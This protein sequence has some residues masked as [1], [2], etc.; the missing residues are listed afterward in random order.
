MTNKNVAAR[1]GIEAHTVS[2][3]RARFV[4]DRLEGLTDEPC[5]GEPRKITDDQVE[6]AIVRTLESTPRDATHWS[7][8]AMATGLGLSQ[9]AISPIWR[10]F[11]L[12]P[13]LVDAF[14][15]SKNPQFIEKVRDGGGL[16]LAPPEHALV[17][18]VDERRRSRR[19]TGRR[20]CCR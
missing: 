20:R 11:G 10:T 15:L 9:S 2:R 12:K 16:Y 17:L 18:C 8:R 7:M 1:L 3:W 14:K 6:E 5:P 13:H 19:W 4:R